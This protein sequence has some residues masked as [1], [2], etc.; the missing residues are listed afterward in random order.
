MTAQ[1]VAP[2]DLELARKFVRG[3]AQHYTPQLFGVPLFGSRARGEAD[4]ESDLDL[5]VTLKRNDP[6]GHVKAAA[7]QLACDL[8]LESG[9]LVSV[10]VADPTFVEQQ[11]VQ[12]HRNGAAG[13]RPGV[14]REE[15]AALMRRAERSLRSARN[16]LDD[17]DHDFAISRAYY[18]MFSAICWISSSRPRRRRMQPQGEVR[19]CGDS[20]R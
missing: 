15:I 6:D 20:Q 13:R 2:G 5:F 17:G 7:R 3:L 9:V 16:L 11:R 1:S 8:T 10:F 14:N 19:A 18:A 4:E 12:L